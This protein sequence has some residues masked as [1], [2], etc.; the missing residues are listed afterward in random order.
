MAVVLNF[1]RN[2][3]RSPNTR[4]EPFSILL[5][6]NPDFES[7][8]ELRVI[9]LFGY[10]DVADTYGLRSDGWTLT[11]EP[12]V[13][14]V[15]LFRRLW[16]DPID[17]IDGGC[18]SFRNPSC[19]RSVP[20][21][22]SMGIAL[23]LVAINEKEDDFFPICC[24]Y[25]YDLDFSR[26]LDSNL[27][28]SC[29]QSAVEGEGGYVQINYILLRDAVDATLEVSFYTSLENLEVCGGIVACYEG[30]FP[31]EC[32]AFEK[33]FYKASLLELNSSILKSGPVQLQKSQMAV[34]R[35]GSLKIEAHL[36]EVNSR[37]KIMRTSC[38]FPAQTESSSQLFLKGIDCCFKVKVNWS[39]VQDVMS[40]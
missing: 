6:L 9:K 20:I 31:F 33:T 2:L 15:E 23:N 16:T 12:D 7:D 21:S 39:Y 8:C 24:N 1:I 32:D 25:M 18:L 34:P 35:K 14:Y 5:N 30:G 13:C 40:K 17:M 27:D 38:D 36:I 28:G 11:Q 29:G 10:I 26:F 4:F 37:T 22:S 19:C 3:P